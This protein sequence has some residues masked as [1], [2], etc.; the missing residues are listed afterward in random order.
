MVSVHACRH[1]AAASDAGTQSC[2]YCAPHGGTHAASFCVRTCRERV[3]GLA[4]GPLGQMMGNAYWLLLYT[5]LHPSAASGALDAHR[6][7][8][9]AAAAVCAVG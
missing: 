4:A 9:I 1:P 3:A 2:G 8:V 6:D 5:A 7:Y